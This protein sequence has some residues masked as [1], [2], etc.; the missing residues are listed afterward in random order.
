MVTIKASRELLRADNIVELRLN[1]MFDDLSMYLVEFEGH[2]DAEVYD[3]ITD[4]YG[5]DLAD[6]YLD[7][8]ESGEEE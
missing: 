4:R 5:Y 2:S 7:W 8:A 6:M 3:L 1:Q